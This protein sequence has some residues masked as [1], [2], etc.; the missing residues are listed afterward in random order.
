MTS[1][2]PLQ[3]ALLAFFVL[4]PILSP[5]YLARRAP[6]RPAL[7]GAPGPSH[8]GTSFVAIPALSMTLP[9]T[10]E[11]RTAIEARVADK[12]GP[13]GLNDDFPA[14]R[15]KPGAFV[16]GRNTSVTDDDRV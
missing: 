13:P 10:A 16:G 4:G 2:Y 11:S 12:A 14:P 5:V 6:G 3:I 1:A 15:H 9:L 8:P 7:L